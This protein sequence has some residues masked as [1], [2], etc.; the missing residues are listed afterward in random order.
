MVVY[1]RTDMVMIERI[2]QQG[3]LEAGW[4]ASAYR[5]LDALNMI[6]VLVGG[7]LFPLFS[8]SF[9]QR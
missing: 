4:Y 7:L 8:R 9:C 1:M 3:D 2:Y 5:L 6:A